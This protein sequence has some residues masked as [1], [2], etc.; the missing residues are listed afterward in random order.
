MGTLHC[1]AHGKA[2][3][4]NQPAADTERLIE[5]ARL[6]PVTMATTTNPNEL[7]SH[8][9]DDEEIV[10]GMRAV[11]AAIRDPDRTVLGEG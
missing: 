4:A 5:P 11:G 6:T 3:L 2:M 7:R 1:T 8:A 9:V 10:V